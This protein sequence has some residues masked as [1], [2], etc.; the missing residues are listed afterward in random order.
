MLAAGPNAGLTL[1]GVEQALFTAQRFR[2][3]PITEIHY[4]PLKIRDIL[5]W[6]ICQFAPPISTQ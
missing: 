1:L 3:L 2:A 4:S 6:P 5:D